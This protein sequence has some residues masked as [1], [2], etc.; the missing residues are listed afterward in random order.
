[1]SRQSFEDKSKLSRCRRVD[2]VMTANVEYI[3]FIFETT[4]SNDAMRFAVCFDF[5][6]RLFSMILL[7]FNFN[8]SMF[9]LKDSAM[10]RDVRLISDKSFDNERLSFIA[11][12][13][14]IDNDDEIIDAD[15]N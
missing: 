9:L 14:R 13:S 7:T 6:T 5:L 10:S 11:R 2:L 8:E 15:F 1:M 3:F 4:M 12:L